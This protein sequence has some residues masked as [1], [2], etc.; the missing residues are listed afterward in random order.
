M[1]VAPVLAELR[2]EGCEPYLKTDTH[3]TPEGM[4]AVAQK[5][6]R[7]LG[8]D[9]DA[10]TP[11]EPKQVTALGDIA[12]MLKLTRPEEAFDP[13]TVTVRQYDFQPSRNGRILLLGDSFTNIYSLEAMNWGVRGGLAERL[14]A[15]LGKPIDVIARNDAGAYATRQL[16]SNELRRGRDRLAGKQVVIWEFAIREL[17]DGDWKLLDLTPGQAPK[18][19]FLTPEKSETVTGTVLAVSEVPRTN[20]APYKDHVMSVHLGDIDGGDNQALVYLASMRD[21]V[22]TKAARLRIGET[23]KVKLSPWA[24]HEAEYGS[25]NRSELDDPELLL[26]EPCWGSLV[27]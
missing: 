23:V 4:A 1:D 5:L 7:E 3:W 25:W 11:G 2:A 21:N 20:S 19:Q 8:A 26:Q 17:A 12:L 18:V 22:W 9:G 16:L 27:P 15:E 14:M 10:S 13:E 6:A 24:D